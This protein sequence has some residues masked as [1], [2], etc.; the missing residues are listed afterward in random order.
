M[1]INPFPVKSRRAELIIALALTLAVLFVDKAH[2]DCSAP[3]TAEERNERVMQVTLIGAGVVAAWGIAEWGYFSRQPQATSEG[4]FGRNTNEGG[5]DKLGHL[6]STYAASQGISALFEHWCFTPDEA[7]WY[8]SLSSL[9]ILGFMEVG[10]SFSDYGFS[11]E[12][13]IANVFGS[14]AGYYR[15]RYPDFARKI[16]LRWEIGLDPNQMD[17][18]TDYE[19]SKFLIA[20]KLNGFD[21]FQKSLLKHVELHAGYF[22]RGYA[23]ASSPDERNLYMGIGVNLTDLFRRHGYRGLATLFNYYQPPKTYLSTE[24]TLAD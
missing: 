11:Y 23:T 15:Y 12:D 4:W 9:A 1:I 8:G 14:L 5:A 20:L 22:A 17:V 21:S 7:A 18:L 3:L 10:D 19:N 13:L 24:R 16:D 6:F 2:A